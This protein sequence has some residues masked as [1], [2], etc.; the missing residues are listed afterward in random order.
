MTTQEVTMTTQ[1]IAKRLVAHCRK[2]NWEAA[3]NELYTEDAIS[4]EPYATPGFEKET[5][6]LKA[7]IEKGRKFNE[8]TE[9]LYSIEV[10]EPLVTPNAIAFVLTIDMTMKGQERMKMPELCVYQV[11]DG[12]I[13]SEQFFM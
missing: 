2:G 9:K 11:K 3:Q 7:I 5:R 1:E 13:I 4:I 12:K 8:M 10:S 6:G